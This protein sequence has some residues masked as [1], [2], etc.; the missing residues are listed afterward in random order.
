MKK[1]IFI[2]TLMVF[3]NGMALSFATEAIDTKAL[4]KPMLNEAQLKK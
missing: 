2:L 4:E 1:T 3:F